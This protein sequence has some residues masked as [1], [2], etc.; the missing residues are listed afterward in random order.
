MTYTTEEIIKN[1][2]EEVDFHKGILKGESV[3]YTTGF[4]AGLK[5]VQEVFRLAEKQIIK[6]DLEAL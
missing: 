5:H 3:K 1:I 6:E 2:Q 4:I